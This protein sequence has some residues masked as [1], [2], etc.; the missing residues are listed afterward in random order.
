M[1]N[2][3]GVDQ[4]NV[5]PKGTPVRLVQPAIQGEII[6]PETNGEQFGY[7]VSYTGAD[8][9]AHERFFAVSQLEVVKVEG[10]GGE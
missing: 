8:G 2:K 3:T 5:L 10:E 7:R 1:D 6:G 9:E 4:V